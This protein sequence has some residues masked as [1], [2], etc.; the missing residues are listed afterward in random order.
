MSQSHEPESAS[1]VAGLAALRALI[2][3]QGF[4]VRRRGFG[5]APEAKE[6]GG[7]WYPTK[8]ITL[9]SP[10][11]IPET[12]FPKGPKGP[13][14]VNKLEYS[15]AVNRRNQLLQMFREKLDS[16]MECKDKIKFFEQMDAIELMI[17]GEVKTHLITCRDYADLGV[18]D[19]KDLLEI[20]FIDNREVVESLAAA[21]A[22]KNAP[23]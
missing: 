16:V 1:K 20:V 6:S 21:A 11:L 8:K 10:Y 5:D 12:M 2:G 7:K 14:N 22:A 19:R 23:K 15:G 17:N 13:I 18:E 4:K 9:V 3:E